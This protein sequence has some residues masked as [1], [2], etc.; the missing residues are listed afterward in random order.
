[1]TGGTQSGIVN[2]RGLMCQQLCGVT[3]NGGA[4]IATGQSQNLK[5]LSPIYFACTTL[6]YNGSLPSVP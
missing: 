5:H 6:K 3:K 1:V 4:P 2:N